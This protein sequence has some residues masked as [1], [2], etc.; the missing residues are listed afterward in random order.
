M[1]RW[2]RDPQKIAPQTAMPNLH[3]KEQDL[4]DI[5]AYLDT[6]KDVNGQ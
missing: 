6:L 2:L 4:R 5:V 3:I 1:T